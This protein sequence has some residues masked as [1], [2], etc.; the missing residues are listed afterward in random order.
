MLAG[1]M[2][3]VRVHAEITAVPIAESSQSDVRAICHRATR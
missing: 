2:A 3:A 1:S